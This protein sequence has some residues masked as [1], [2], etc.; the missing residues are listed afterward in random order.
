MAPPA[1]IED[2]CQL[3]WSHLIRHR[4]RVDA[5]HALAWLATTAT[6]E[7]FRLLA[8]EQREQSLERELEERGDGAL[9]RRVPGPHELLEARQRLVHIGGVSERQ[10]RL[11]WL[12]AFGLD[13]DEMAGHEG[14]SR[15]TVERQLLRA[16]RA[17]RE[18]GCAQASAYRA[19]PRLRR[20]RSAGLSLRDFWAR[21]EPGLL[22]PAVASAVR[23]RTGA[24]RRASY[25]MKPAMPSRMASA[26]T[27]MATAAPLLSPPPGELAG[28][29]LV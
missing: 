22:P 26:P 21:L 3:A 5:E 18:S 29:E 4:Q 16:K 10:K 2:A 14:C 24:R 13:Y 28:L 8:R 11:L 15:R 27:P 23:L 12:H 25:Q 6:R 20:L 9:P 17:V 19:R 1:V 7:A